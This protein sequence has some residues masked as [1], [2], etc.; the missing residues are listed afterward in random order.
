MHQ[1]RIKQ[2][3]T[4]LPAKEDNAKCQGWTMMQDWDF[5]NSRSLTP[6]SISHSFRD[7]LSLLSCVM[8]FL[9]LPASHRNVDLM[10]SLLMSSHPPTW[11]RTII[12]QVLWKAYFSDTLPTASQKTF[13]HAQLEL[14]EP[15]PNAVWCCFTIFPTRKVFVC[16]V[17]VTSQLSAGPCTCWLSLW[18]RYLFSLSL[19]LNP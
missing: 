3:F 13:P 4:A 1:W 19:I 17:S 9:L 6:H 15:Q 5:S 18:S 16:T 12:Q 2:T 8:P 14:S 7:S 10:G 11:I